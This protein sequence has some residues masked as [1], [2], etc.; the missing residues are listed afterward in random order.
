[1]SFLTRRI[2]N[3]ALRLCLLLVIF[4][5]LALGF[6]VYAAF[7]EEQPV[8]WDTAEAKRVSYTPWE[9]II[10]GEGLPAELEIQSANNN[11]DIVNYQGRFFLVFRTAPTHFASSRTRLYVLSSEDRKQWDHEIDFQIGADL[12]EPRFLILN[13]RLIL[14]FL[15]GGK[16]MLEFD[17][18]QT[19]AIERIGPREWTDPKPVFKPGYVMWRF[20]S[21][22]DTAYAA[23]YYGQGLYDATTSKGEVRLLTSKDGFTY[24]PITDHPQVTLPGAEEPEF[25]FDEAGNLVI[26]IR[27]ELY[28]GSLLC[29]AP[30]DNLGE[31]T[32]YHSPF[33]YDS[34]CMF[35]QEDTFYVIARRNL[36]GAHQRMPAWLGEG[37]RRMADLAFYSLTRKRTALYRIDFETKSLIPLFD[38]PSRGDTAFAG[39]TPLGN[40]QGTYWVANYTC[41]LKGPDW[42]W[43]FGQLIGTRIYGTTLTFSQ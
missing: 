1:M 26:L 13:G 9:Q 39:I 21:R 29:T 2:G 14:Y 24:E 38:F 20:K 18:G 32:T 35:R 16:K 7:Y 3:Y 42:P 23:V 37:L 6:I 41:D 36:A 22:G 4:V 30:Y 19:F 43:L 17:P 10:P 15:Q 11:L 25:E 33:K 27:L 8:H 34:S 40:Q 31:W 28:G 5:G 12:R